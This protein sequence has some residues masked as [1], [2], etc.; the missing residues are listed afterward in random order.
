MK[1]S[2]NIKFTNKEI[3]LKRYRWEEK[4]KDEHVFRILLQ[5]VVYEYINVFCQGGKSETPILPYSHCT[6]TVLPL[7][8][9]CTPI[10]LPLYSH[11]TPTVLPLYSHV[12]HCT[13]TYSHCTPTYS[14]CTPTYSHYTPKKFGSTWSLAFPP[15]LDSVSCIWMI[16]PCELAIPW[17]VAAITIKNDQALIE[18]NFF[19]LHCQWAPCVLVIRTLAKL[20]LCRST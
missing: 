3:R 12:P 2:N 1:W 10:V 15:L 17:I 11:C 14:H 8:S 18:K 6:P 20:E 19:Y 13:P 4:K 7:Y 9:H 5:L 16:D